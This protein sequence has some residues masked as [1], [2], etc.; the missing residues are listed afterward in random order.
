MWLCVLVSFCPTSGL[1]LRMQSL[2][3]QRVVAR[4]EWWKESK[5]GRWQGGW[6]AR[7]DKVCLNILVQR[8]REKIRPTFVGK[9]LDKQTIISRPAFIYHTK[10]YDAVSTIFVAFSIGACVRVY[11]GREI[12]LPSAFQAPPWLLIPFHNITYSNLDDPDDLSGFLGY[13][14]VWY[15]CAIEKSRF[16]LLRSR[17]P[18]LRSASQMKKFSNLF[19]HIR[20]I[21]LWGSVYAVW[22]GLYVHIYVFDTTQRSTKICP[23]GTIAPVPKTTMFCYGRES[24]LFASLPGLSKNQIHDCTWHVGTKASWCYAWFVPRTFRQNNV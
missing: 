6:H 16:Q 4:R 2:V 22:I 21:L 3:R 1:V 10:Y 8:S 23:F 9:I 5:V 13:H 7:C 14:Y 17:F 19:P 20:V 15:E 18:I 12:H 24:G 11:F